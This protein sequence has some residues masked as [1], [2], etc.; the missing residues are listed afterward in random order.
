MVS[1]M[2]NFLASLLLLL[3]ATIAACATPGD[4]DVDVCFPG[5]KCDSFDAHGIAP[6]GDRMANVL[7]GYNPLTDRVT[8]PAPPR[9]CVSIRLPGSPSRSA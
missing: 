3:L 4:D 5:E 2:R 9:R 1:A 6:T 8:A 7:S